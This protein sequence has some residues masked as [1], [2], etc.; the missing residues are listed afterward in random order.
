MIEVGEMSDGQFFTAAMVFAADDAGDDSDDAAD[1]AERDR[2]DQE[3][4]ENIAT[5]R[6]H[7]HARPDF[8]RPLGDAHQ[9]DVHDPNAA[10]DQRNDGNPGEQCCHRL[11]RRRGR[12][13]NFFLVPDGKIVVPP[14]A[15]IMPLP[16]QRDDLL[17]RRHEIASSWRPAR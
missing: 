9:H 7:R 8:A 15:N 12:R 10:D 2:L 1:R 3:L 6:A 5:V 17:L 4:R 13:R 11:G 14:F 16:E